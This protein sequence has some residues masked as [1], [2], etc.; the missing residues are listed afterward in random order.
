MGTAHTSKRP[1]LKYH[2][3]FCTTQVIRHGEKPGGKK[4]HGLSPAGKRRAQCLKRVFGSGDLKAQY[5]MAPA[6]KRS[7][8][9]RRAYDTLKPLSRYTGMPLDTSCQRDDSSCVHKVLERETSKGNNVVVAWQHTAISS[10]VR[11]LGVKGLVWDK[12]RYDMIIHIKKGKVHRIDSE[13]CEGLDKRWLHW[14]AKK[15]NGKGKGGQY[16]RIVDD[17]SWAEGAGEDQIPLA[18]KG[19][20]FAS[21]FVAYDEDDNAE[22]DLEEDVDLDDVFGRQ[23]LG[24]AMTNWFGMR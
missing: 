24:S 17:E 4:H 5:A 7:G 2:L 16:G 19:A 22:E 13:E 21:S 11:G 3:A 23:S 6:Y 12:K 1:P 18:T 14:H 10:L 9:R 20:S 8:A 15:G